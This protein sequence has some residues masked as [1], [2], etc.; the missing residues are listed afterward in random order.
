MVFTTTISMV[1]VFFPK[2]AQALKQSLIKHW[3]RPRQYA[4]NRF[5]QPRTS[6]VIRSWRLHLIDLDSPF[7]F[8]RMR[9]HCKQIYRNVRVH[10]YTDMFVSLTQ[11]QFNPMRP[12]I[13]LFGALLTTY[14]LYLWHCLECFLRWEAAMAP[15][16]LKLRQKQRWLVIRDLHK[17]RMFPM[18]HFCLEL[19]K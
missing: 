13:V 10:F 14:Q 5:L 7:F 18:S 1:L 4:P 8:P 19:K 16:K 15:R 3:A 12:E 17:F 2:A 6:Q 9:K 11:S